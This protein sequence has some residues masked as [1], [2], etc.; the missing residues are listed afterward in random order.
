MSM[1]NSVSRHYEQMKWIIAKAEL[2]DENKRGSLS[3]QKPKSSSTFDMHERV[4]GLHLG[5]RSANLPDVIGWLKS[6]KIDMYGYNHFEEKIQGSSLPDIGMHWD[7]YECEPMSST[8]HTV[9]EFMQQH[10]HRTPVVFENEYWYHQK[11]AQK[12]IVKI[13]DLSKDDLLIISV[14]FYSNF[15]N[16]PSIDDILSRC[17]E[18]GIPVVLDL[19][20]LPLTKES[21][22][23]AHTDCVEVVTHSISKMLP[24]AGMKGGFAYWKKPVSKEQSLYPL[25]NKLIYHIGKRFIDEFGYHYVRDKFVPY[26]SKWCRILG[27]E[28]HDLCYVGRIP[29]GHWLESENLH[30]HEFQVGDKLFN[31][32]PYMENDD[33]LSKFLDDNRQ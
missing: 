28:Q 8:V 14:P 26:Q 11:L 2:A 31:L 30:A 27:L 20:W 29:K 9:L 32:V 1:D 4:S 33:I 6:V 19:I 25:G 21:I 3:Y 17:T 13:D 7:E 15:K 24:M 10:R 22:K 5:L 16:H 18:L 12:T 23:L